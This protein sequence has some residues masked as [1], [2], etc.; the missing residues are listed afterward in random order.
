MSRPIV[1]IVCM[2][3]ASESWEPQQLPQPWHPR[4]RWRSRPQLQERKPVSFMRLLSRALPANWYCKLKNRAIG[5][6]LDKPQ[7]APVVCNQR[8]RDGEPQSHTTRFC[9]KEWI[10]YALSVHGGNSRPGVLDQHQYGRWTVETRF[11]PQ[12]SCFRGRG[13]H[14]IDS[15]SDEV[16]EYLLKFHAIYLHLGKVALKLRSNGYSVDL[17]IVL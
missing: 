7:F 2:D 5:V 10:E 11:E 1:V 13:A 15:V 12:P 17:K 9:R 3:S 4:C 6:R 16:Q 14:C 8:R